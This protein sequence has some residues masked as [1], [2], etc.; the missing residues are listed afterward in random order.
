ML[1]VVAR[2]DGA[3]N[4]YRAKGFALPL[5]KSIPVGKSPGEMCVDPGQKT[6]Y[7]GEIS[8]KGIA[9]I[10]LAAQSVA[11]TISNPA[12]VHPDGCAVSPDG[13]K[14]YLIDAGSASV[15]VFSTATHE[16]LAKISVGDEPRRALFTPDGKQ[17]LVSNAHS[18]TISV[19]DTASDKVVRTIKTGHEPR[20]MLWTPDGK[21]LVVSLVVDDSIA[22][23]NASNLE[24]EQQSGTERS[25]QRLAISPDGK[26]LFSLSRFYDALTIVDL[27]GPDARR[28][29]Q[30]IPVGKYSFG[31][32]MSADGKY[33][34]TAAS[35]LDNTIS[36]ID[37]RLMRVANVL[38]GGKGP[39]AML[40]LK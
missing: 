3:L 1:A 33:V 10:D 24:F 12:L 27:E 40:Y 19:I 2:G 37:V 34:Y 23:F 6:L 35:I 15:F 13:Q 17:M 39:S 30:S 29:V 18:D 22:Y 16:M 28:V 7:V 21:H 25:P 20:E 38:P 32:A 9:A 31:M 36:V 26:T 5:V 11:Y 14:L 4:L 8:E